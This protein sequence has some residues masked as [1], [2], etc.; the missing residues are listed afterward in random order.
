V[1][2]HSPGRDKKDADVTKRLRREVVDLIDSHP[3]EG[4]RNFL[5][6]VAADIEARIECLND[7]EAED[8]DHG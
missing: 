1:A 5:E 4:F 7:E 6:E 2:K 8:P 3:P